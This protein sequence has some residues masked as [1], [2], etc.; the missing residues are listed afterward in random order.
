MTKTCYNIWILLN[1]LCFFWF[2]SHV[3]VVNDVQASF[4][5]L[6]VLYRKSSVQA[7][8]QILNKK[9]TLCKG[10][11]L[12]KISSPVKS[13][14]KKDLPLETC[15]SNCL[16][17]SCSWCQ[18]RVSDRE[19]FKRHISLHNFF[20]QGC[21]MHCP[22]CSYTTPSAVVL[23]KHIPMHMD[24][25]PFGCRHCGFSAKTK[26][27]VVRHCKRSHPDIPVKLVN[28]STCS[29]KL[30][31]S[32]P[33]VSFSPKVRLKKCAFDDEQMSYLNMEDKPQNSKT[34]N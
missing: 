11:P 19:H 22:Y 24:K 25:H 5:F 26:M 21:K 18:F 16:F 13:D 12:H 1:S 30:R 3:C 28:R 15:K 14:T 9:R 8:S 34:K 32:W 17:F 2:F 33:V 31:P 20:P 27:M 4:N 7:Q 6:F 10:R 29:Q 23:E